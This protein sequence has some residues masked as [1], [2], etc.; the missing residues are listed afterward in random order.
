MAKI[1]CK[2][3]VIEYTK[4]FK[5]KVVE[6]TQGLKVNSTEIADILGLHPVMVYRWRQEYREGKL[7]YEP[8]R[9][10]SMTTEKTVPIQ[11]P[12][13]QQEQAE[14]KQLRKERVRLKKE[15]DVLKKWQGYL[16]ELKQNDSNS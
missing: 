14:L 1:N 6:L 16:K 11:P 9:R 5:V 12:L 4:E 10:I 2:E 15:N 8:S 3:R 7:V 13:N